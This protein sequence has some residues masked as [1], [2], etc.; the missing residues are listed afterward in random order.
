[1]CDKEIGPQ[2]KM[3]RKFFSMPQ[4]MTTHK[5]ENRK[6]NQK[7][8]DLVPSGFHLFGAL[9]VAIHGKRFGSDNKV[10]KQ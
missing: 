10:M 4:C 6:I 1:V 5:F 9:K 8:P 2:K 7:T 3:L